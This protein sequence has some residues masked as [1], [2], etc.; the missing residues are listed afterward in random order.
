MDKLYFDVD[1][2]LN[3]TAATPEFHFHVDK[4]ERL[5]RLKSMFK[6]ELICVSYW[7]FHE[8]VNNLPFAFSIMKHIDKSQTPLDGLI[9]DDQ[10]TFYTEDHLVYQ[11]RSSE[12]LTEADLRNIQ[13]YY[14]T[15]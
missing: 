9:I 14:R 10:P 13:I 8:C 4:V 5:L 3:T 15:N 2:V 11:T 7:R 1:G 6:L 12:G